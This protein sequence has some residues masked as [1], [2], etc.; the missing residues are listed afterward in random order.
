MNKELMKGTT[1]TLVLKI[2]KREPMYGYAII[3]EIEVRSNGVFSL[4]EGTLYPILHDLETSGCVEA[5]WEV[6]ENRRR[7]YYRI[8]KQG[9]KMLDEKVTEWRIFSQAVGDVL[10][11]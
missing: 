5:Y 6:F 8:T 4:K 3:K 10:V 11:N 1:V 9:L 2:L 7:K